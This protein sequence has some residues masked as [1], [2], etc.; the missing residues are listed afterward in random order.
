MKH[1][2]QKKEPLKAKIKNIRK[3]RCYALYMIIILKICVL[4]P[5]AIYACDV[6]IGVNVLEDSELGL[7][8]VTHQ[9]N[10]FNDPATAPLLSVADHPYSH[11]FPNTVLSSVSNIVGYI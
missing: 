3:R 10:V 7:D 5:I 2:F 1:I 9:Q 11:K 6:I 4:L 8:L